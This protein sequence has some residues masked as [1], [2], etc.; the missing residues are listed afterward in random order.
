VEIAPGIHRIESDLG[1]RFV[2]QY[3][4][5]GAERTLLVDT[6]LRDTPAE[7]I[8]PYLERIGLGVDAIDVVLI[9]HADVDHC[10]GNRRLQ[11]LHPGALFAAHRLDVPWIERN[12]AM[13][14]ENYA[15]YEAYGF[16]PDPDTLAFLREQLGGDSTVH[17]GLS[18]G[19][20]LRLGS[21]T[22]LEVLH[23]PGHTQGHLGLWDHERRI[24]IVIDAVLERGVYDRAGRRLLP[25]RY[26]DA[27]QYRQTIRRLRELEP[28]LLLTAHYDVLAGAAVAAFLDRCLDHDRDVE[29][30]VHVGLRAGLRTLRD[31]TRFADERLGPYPEF[32]IELAASV[33]S[34]ALAAGARVH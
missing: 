3:L 2:C 23:L 10:G 14:D 16:G 13:L 5:V 6:G 9:S 25:P 27:A 1:E 32:T 20:L 31:L 26:Y 17:L 15:W 4:V 24:A 33:R 8:A 12:A 7:V 30:A 29:A 19:E 22:E 21:G 28:E 11:E 34:H 18:G